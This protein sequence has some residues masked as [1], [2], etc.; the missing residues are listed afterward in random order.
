MKLVSIVM[1]LALAAPPAASQPE[2][3]LDLQ[4]DEALSHF[5]V[6][7]EAW[8]AKDYTTAQRELETAYELEPR[9]PLLYS[10]GQLARLQGDC[11]L[12]RERFEAYLETEPSPEAAEDTR[13]NIERCEPAQP[14]PPPVVEAPTEPPPD[15][16]VDRPPPPPRKQGPDVLGLSLTI[17]GSV[18]AVTGAGLLGAAFAERRRADD[19]FGVDEFE[20]RVDR[21]QAEYWAGVALTS[22]GAALLVGGI[23]RL[24][25]VRRRRARSVAFSP[26]VRQVASSRYSW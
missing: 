9:P 13:V 2:N 5:T 8:L 6:G 3:P 25:L 20:Q 4:S 23:T 19:A 14:V 18:I 11:D 7:M 15:E 24:L 21:A 16:L 22:V 10:L 26:R 17:G 12:A 1:A